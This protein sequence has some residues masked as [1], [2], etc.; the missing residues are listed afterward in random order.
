MA[1][2]GRPSLPLAALLGDTT[3]ARW[4]AKEGVPESRRT[5]L[6]DDRVALFVWWV[7]CRRVFLVPLGFATALLCGPARAELPA[8]ASARGQLL[9]TPRAL[10]GQVLNGPTISP[11][12]GLAQAAGHPRLRADHVLTT[13]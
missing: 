10:A 8:R 7:P 9:R 12:T 1:G 3:L 5:I 6:A 11:P 13:C 2:C 4:E